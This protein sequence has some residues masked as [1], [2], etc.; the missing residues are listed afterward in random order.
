MT[1]IKIRRDMTTLK[2]SFNSDFSGTKS[3][4]ARFRFNYYNLY[5]K[6]GLSV[7]N[8]VLTIELEILNKN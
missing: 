6:K 3:V 8:S 4:F 1:G 2:S 5:I 7:V